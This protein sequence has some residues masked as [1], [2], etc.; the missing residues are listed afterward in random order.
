[1]MNDSAIVTQIKDAVFKLTKQH[2][3]K[4]EM[5]PPFREDDLERVRFVSRDPDGLVKGFIEEPYYNNDVRGYVAHTGSKESETA[6]FF[7]KSRND[8]GGTVV[9]IEDRFIPFVS[10]HYHR[11]L[12]VVDDL[13]GKDD[14]TINMLPSTI[15]ML[16]STMNIEDVNYVSRDESGLIKGFKYR[17]RIDTRSYFD[18]DVYVEDRGAIFN[19]RGKNKK[20]HLVQVRT[21]D[22]LREM[23]ILEDEY[24][25]NEE[26]FEEES[27]LDP[28]AFIE[29]IIRQ[30]NTLVLGKADFDVMKEVYD[31][32]GAT[33]PEK[34][35][36][37]VIKPNGFGE[38]KEGSGRMMISFG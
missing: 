15:N 29:E 34:Y 10:E 7:V 3:S 22:E 23:G 8:M 12:R 4:F 37:L 20:T 26:Y 21:D 27:S 33:V 17:P 16:P 31:I 28:Y 2:P 30:G 18:K 9:T 1:M 11:V 35:P 13:S 24:E 5:I 36:L 19:A 32:V 38:I 6:V 14:T 25:E